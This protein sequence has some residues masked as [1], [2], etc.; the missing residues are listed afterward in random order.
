MLNICF[1]IL[2]LTIE[3]LK[4]VVAV[5]WNCMLGHHVHFPRLEKE[6]R[7]FREIKYIWFEW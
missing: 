2:A 1:W 5:E 4:K 6:Q 3:Q 7:Y